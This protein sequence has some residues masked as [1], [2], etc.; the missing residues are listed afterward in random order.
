M[1]K[2]APLNQMKFDP[3]RPPL[4]GSPIALLGLA[5]K[6]AATAGKIVSKIVQN[7]VSKHGNDAVKVGEQVAKDLGEHIKPSIVN[8]RNAEIT[9]AN[10]L[11][12]TPS[13][14]GS[15]TGSRSVVNSTESINYVKPG[16]SQAQADSSTRG[17]ATARQNTLNVGK[18]SGT[19][20][21]INISTKAATTGVKA[22]AKATGLAAIPVVGAAAK[23]GYDV[24]KSQSNKKS[25]K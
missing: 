14:T 20:A 9:S 10:V 11:K 22:G 3:K 5:E 7:A 15:T 18:T 2:S 21:A 24:G 12:G 4:Q 1:A 19:K 25:G 6:G 23:I 17:L 16:I 8:A 13:T